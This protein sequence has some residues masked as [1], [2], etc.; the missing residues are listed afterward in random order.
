VDVRQIDR[1]TEMGETMMMGL[2]LT[3]E[4]VSSKRFEAR[5]GVSL[6][7]AFDKPIRD[8][9]R[10]GLLEWAGDAG[11]VL[12]LTQRGRLLGNRVFMEFI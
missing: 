9:Q 11:E 1:E 10:A 8:L 4:G 5:F 7:A 12:R 6:E 2:R 3:E